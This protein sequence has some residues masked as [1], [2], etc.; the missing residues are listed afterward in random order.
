MGNIALACRKS[1]ETSTQEE[2][3]EHLVKCSR[4]DVLALV[5]LSVL[6]ACTYASTSTLSFLLGII[7]VVLTAVDAVALRRLTTP[8]S[9]TGAAPPP[10]V[11]TCLAI[12]TVNGAN[13]ALTGARA[14]LTV[15][16]R[17][18]SFSWARLC[19]VAVYLLILSNKFALLVVL[20]WFRRKLAGGARKGT[21]DSP[22]ISLDEPLMVEEGFGGAR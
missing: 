17:T 7:L 5:I 1:M 11:A 21:P 2:V 20:A 22:A 10:T 3:T 6:L 4:I 9:A 16:E 15:L 8:P 14:I 18:E 13:L 19:L 12:E